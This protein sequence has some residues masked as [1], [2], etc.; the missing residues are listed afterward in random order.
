[1]RSLSLRE[2]EAEA[3]PCLA[4]SIYEYFAGGAGDEVTLRANESAFARFA[5]VPRVLRGAGAPDLG[6]TLLGCAASMP[7]LIAPTDRKSVV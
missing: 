4:P 7:I 3:R 1:M 2:L 5:L 6:V